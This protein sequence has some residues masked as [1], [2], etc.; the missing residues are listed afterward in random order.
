MGQL[1]NDGQDLVA[2]SGHPDTLWQ[3]L[4]TTTPN[5]DGTSVSEPVG[6]NYARLSLTIGAAAGGD[7][8][9][10]NTNAVTHTAAGGDWGTQ[11]HSVYFTAVSGGTFVAFDD[12]D[13]PRNMVDGATMDFGIGDY[14]FVQT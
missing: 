3:G 10:E 11:T 2:N 12:L 4:S 1:S 8:T 13:A 7:G 5:A 6:N 14:D 9:R